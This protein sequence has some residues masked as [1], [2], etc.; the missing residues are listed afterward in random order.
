MNARA[1]KNHIHS[2]LI[3]QKFERTQLEQAY[4]HHVTQ[5]KDHAQMKALLK[6][7]NKTISNLVGKYNRLVD[8]MRDLKKCNK[9]LLRAQIPPILQTQQLFC[10]DIYDD[11]WNEV[12]LDDNDGAEPPGWL[13]NNKI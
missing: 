10:L 2:K 5:E 11:I 12:G 7:S 3:S 9:A 13:S 8:L 4:H 1:V 6:H